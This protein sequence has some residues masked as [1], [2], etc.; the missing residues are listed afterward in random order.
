MFVAIAATIFAAVATFGSNVTGIATSAIEE[1]VS[2]PMTW[3]DAPEY[4]V[5]LGDDNR[6]GVIDEDESGWDCATMGN[7]I[8]GPIVEDCQ[9]WD[10][11]WNGIFFT[12]GA[13]DYSLPLCFYSVQGTK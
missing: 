1:H 5:E 11:T 12:Y 7:Q 3:E 8:C 10:Y 13:R 4:M 2:A 6:D 9:K